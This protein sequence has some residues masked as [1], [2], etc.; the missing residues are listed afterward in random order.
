MLAS[1]LKKISSYFFP[2]AFFPSY[3]HSPVLL[4]PFPFP[5]F[6]F[7][8]Y[9]QYIIILFEKKS[10]EAGGNCH[11]VSHMPKCKRLACW[12]FVVS[13]CEHSLMVLSYS[14]I[15]FKLLSQEGS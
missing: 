14:T 9:I 8:N 1:A 7:C 11:R 12:F 5:L 4:P 10:V 2:I 15:Q 6:F 13:K 3:L